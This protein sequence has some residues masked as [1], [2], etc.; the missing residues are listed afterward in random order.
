MTHQSKDD[1]DIHKGAVEDDQPHQE[2]NTSMRGQLNHRSHDAMIKANDSDFPEPGG[3]PEHTGEPQEDPE[4]RERKPPVSEQK[5][6]SKKKDP[7]AG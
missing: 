7:I 1:N 3:N 5:S 4:A 6:G 2:H